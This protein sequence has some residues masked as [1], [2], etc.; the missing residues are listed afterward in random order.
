MQTNPINIIKSTYDQALALARQGDFRKAA[1]LLDGL[2][3]KAPNQPEIH[4]QRARMADKLGDPEKRLSSIDRAVALRGTEPAILNE[5][6][7]AHKSAGHHDI[8]LKLY[9]SLIALDPKAIKPQA[10]KALYLQTA[11]RFDESEKLLRKLQKKNPHDAELYRMLATTIRIAPND[12]MIGAMRRLANHPRLSAQGR[13]HINFALAKAM[14][15]TK[16]IAKVFPHLRVAN[17]TQA[18]LFPD[19]PAARAAEHQG[20]L[21]AQEGLAPISASQGTD[22]ALIFVTGLPRSG[23]TLVEQIIASHSQVH[24]GGEMATALRTAYSIFGQGAEMRSLSDEPA[25]SF[26]SFVARLSAANRPYADTSKPNLTDKS[27]MAFLIYGLLHATLPNARFIVVHRDPRDIALSIYKNHF[28]SGTHRYANDLASIAEVIK[29]FR[30]IIAHWRAVLPDRFAEIHYEDLVL[31]PETQ[32]RK[33]I[34][35]A[36]LDWEDQCLNF[37]KKGGT[38]KTLSLHQVRQPIYKSSA[39]AWRRYETE[40]QPFID[41]WG[42]TPWD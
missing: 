26:Q 33:L 14:E 9:D 40:L 8:V 13:M 17:K 31:E 21:N 32:S 20:V 7:A 3:L 19:D 36:G 16:N 24:A 18:E 1:G 39:A 23:T 42:D 34:T 12:P 5:A 30:K 27:I 29:S 4:F 22:P 11:G 41:A 15:D 38:I 25:Q 37:H 28:N 2:A 10:E 6:I 35:A